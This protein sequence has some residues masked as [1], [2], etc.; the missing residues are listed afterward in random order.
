VRK[1]FRTQ[2]SLRE[3]LEASTIAQL[4]QAIER[5]EQQAALANQVLDEVALD[6]R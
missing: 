5:Q 1:A 2:L 6:A 3:W 4:A